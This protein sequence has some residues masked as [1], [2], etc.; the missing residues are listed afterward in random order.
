M[1]RKKLGRTYWDFCVCVCVFCFWLLIDAGP[2]YLARNNCLVLPA[3]LCHPK[4]NNTCELPQWEKIQLFKKPVLVHWQKMYIYLCKVSTESSLAV[5]LSWWTTD[6]W[7][8]KGAVYHEGLTVRISEASTNDIQKPSRKQPLVLSWYIK[9]SM[10]IR[11]EE[12]WWLPVRQGAYST[13][14]VKF[15]TE[16]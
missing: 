16:R 2:T 7:R 13:K 12:R 15:S 9:A 3:P 14:L 10:P 11:F 8:T 4:K 1:I 6:F 5:T